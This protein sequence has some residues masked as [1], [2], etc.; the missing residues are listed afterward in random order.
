MKISNSIPPVKLLDQAGA[1]RIARVC[2]GSIAFREQRQRAVDSLSA[3]GLP[4]A[5]MEDVDFAVGPTFVLRG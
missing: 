2:C 5:T 1:R 4:T 3:C